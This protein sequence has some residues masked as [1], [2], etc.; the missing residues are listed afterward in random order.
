MD[1]NSLNILRICKILR[2]LDFS[3]VYVPQLLDPEAES[4][5]I[6]AYVSMQ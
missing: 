4:A 3:G 1:K 2:V 6:K 5:R